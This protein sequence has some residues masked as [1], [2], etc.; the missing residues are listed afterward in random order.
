MFEDRF[1]LWTLQKRRI[2]SPGEK[3]GTSSIR[4]QA[5]KGIKVGSDD[6]VLTRSQLPARRS[7]ELKAVTGWYV[8][9]G[10]HN[11]VRFKHQENGCKVRMGWFLEN[12]FEEMPNGVFLKNCVLCR[13]YYYSLF[14]ELSDVVGPLMNI[15]LSKVG[16]VVSFL[17]ITLIGRSLGLVYQGIRQ[18]VRWPTNQKKDK[19]AL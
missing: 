15:L 8:P 12:G 9:C 4:M 5:K 16:D 18:S 14:L 2:P 11:L 13:R 6:L 3:Q 17:L 7:T 19:Q 1:D 10:G